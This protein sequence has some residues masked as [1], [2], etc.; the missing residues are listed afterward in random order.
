MSDVKYQR[1]KLN[2]FT[3]RAP[4]IQQPLAR[5]PWARLDRLVWLRLL[6]ANLRRTG[7][8]GP[9]VLIA[10]DPAALTPGGRSQSPVRYQFQG[11]SNTE[12]SPNKKAPEYRR[13]LGGPSE[14]AF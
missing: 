12:H 7:A 5:Q 9:L 10:L 11:E 6:L 3:R 8:C 14:L 2:A 4:K 1:L 13:P